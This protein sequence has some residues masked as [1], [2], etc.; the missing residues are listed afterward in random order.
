MTADFAS[1]LA[2]LNAAVAET[3]AVRQKLERRFAD[4]AIAVERANQRH[5][6]AIR[7]LE[8]RLADAAAARSRAEEQTIAE[9]DGATEKAVQRQ[10]AFDAELMRE[11]SKRQKLASALTDTTAALKATEQRAAGERQAAVE[12]AAQSQENFEATLRQEVSRRLM[13]EEEFARRFDNA[14]VNMCQCSRDG[15]ITQVNKTFARFLGY[16]NPKDLQ[17]VD[18]GAAI[19]E[20]GD[21]LQWLVD[22]CLGSRAPESIETTWKRKDGTRAIVRVLAVAATRDSIDVAA[23]DVTTLREIEEKLRN[24]QRM[25]AVARYASE[26]AVNCDNLLTH[27][28]QEGERWLPKIEDEAARYQAELLLDEVKRAAGF[29]R[30]LGVY[31]NE[32]RNIAEL[33]EVNKVLRDM[34]PVLKRVAGDNI[35]LVLP[36]AA[37]PLNVDVDAERVER[38]LVN[39][40]AYGRE[41]M[42]LG[43]RLMIDVSSVVVDRTFVSKYPNV[44]PGAHVLLTVNEVRGPVRPDFLKAADAHPSGTSAAASGNPGVDLGALQALVSDCGGHLW[45]MAEPPGDMVLKIHLPRRAL[46]DLDSGSKA[47]RRLGTRFVNRLPSIR[48]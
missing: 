31:G 43:G 8:A 23:E 28:K 44:R 35:D 21:E 13:A 24:S 41:R 29:L 16:T 11:V 34:E 3:A 18:F 46:D 37:A 27:V 39:V 32:Q 9:R 5:A 48:H 45:M 15:S 19:F 26:V 33:V 6:A 36:K 2:Q 14:P 10:S 17:N 25:E 47:K 38:M 40:A 30:Q 4:A 12:Q 42:P 1:A 22:R 20:S 7:A